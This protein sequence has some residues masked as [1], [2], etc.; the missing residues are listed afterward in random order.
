MSAFG[1]LINIWLEDESNATHFKIDNLIIVNRCQFSRNQ[2]TGIF[3]HESIK[4]E[5]FDTEF[6]SIVLL[7]SKSLFFLWPVFISIIRHPNQKPNS[8]WTL[9]SFWNNSLKKFTAYTK[10]VR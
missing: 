5:V 7:K 3:V 1:L 8:L 9:I 10:L 2:S 6:E 4:A